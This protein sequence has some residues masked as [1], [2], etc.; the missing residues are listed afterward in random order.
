MIK[1][2]GLFENM[3]EFEW[4]LGEYKKETINLPSDFNCSPLRADTKS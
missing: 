4:L 3:I 1:V 2:S